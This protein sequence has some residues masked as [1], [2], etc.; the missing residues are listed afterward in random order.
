MILPLLGKALLGAGK[1]AAKSFAKREA[2]RKTKKIATDKFLNRDKKE[3]NFNW[4]EQR[5]SM[6]PGVKN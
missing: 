4:Q 6:L 3:K 2:A 1:T 5:P